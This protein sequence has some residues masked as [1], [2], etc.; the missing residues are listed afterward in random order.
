MGLCRY[1]AKPSLSAR[2]SR[3]PSEVRGREGGCPL[4]GARGSRACACGS[5][6]NPACG[7]GAWMAGEGA[8]AVGERGWRAMMSTFFFYESG[9]PCQVAIG[10]FPVCVCRLGRW[11][12]QSWTVTRHS[13]LA[14][15]YQPS[16]S[17]A[18]SAPPLGQDANLTFP[19][20]DVDANMVHGWP[21][22]SAALTACNP[23]GAL[24]ATTSS[25]RPAAFIPSCVQRRLTRSRGVSP[26]GVR[27]RAP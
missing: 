13:S 16:G 11:P 6:R 26:F 23:C 20:V 17:A 4:T 27:A 22:L 10:F 15:F 24:Y 8:H 7:G 2:D 14:T 19:L 25:G 1:A 21:L 12:V 18:R 5:S 9:W 3:R